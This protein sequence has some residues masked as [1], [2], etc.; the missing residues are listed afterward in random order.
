[1]KILAT[2]V[3]RNTKLL[4]V[5]GKGKQNRLADLVVDSGTTISRRALALG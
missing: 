4:A 3:L 1:M 2:I 5:Q